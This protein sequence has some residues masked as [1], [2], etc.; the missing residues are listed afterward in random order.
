MIS[1]IIT[2]FEA[3]DLIKKCIKRILNQEDFNEK[4][5]IIAACPDEPTKKIILNYKK[6]YPKIIKYIRQDYTCPKNALMNKILKKAKGRILIWTDGNKYFDENTI[7][8]LLEPFEDKKVGIVG[9]RIILMN[10]KDNIYGIW[11]SLLTKNLHKMR[12]IAIE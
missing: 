6:K 7:K 4:F 10:P 5:E 2:A 9:G 11:N 12:K 8:L 1:I 3:H